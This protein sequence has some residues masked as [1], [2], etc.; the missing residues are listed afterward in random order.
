MSS[1]AKATAAKLAR[2]AAAD[3]L[4]AVSA[5]GVGVQPLWNVER[6]GRDFQ[7]FELLEDPTEVHH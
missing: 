6:W 2:A 4:A 3:A 1:M 5:A 7:A